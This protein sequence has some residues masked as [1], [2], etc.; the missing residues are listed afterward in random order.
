MDGA[1]LILDQEMSGLVCGINGRR[2]VT[3]EVMASVYVTRE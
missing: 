3:L 2:G 1:M